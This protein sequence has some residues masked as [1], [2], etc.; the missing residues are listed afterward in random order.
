MSK[1][2]EEIQFE[3]ELKEDIEKMFKAGCSAY[4]EKA[5]DELTETAKVA[6]KQFYDDYEPKY[7]KR[8][9]NLLKNSY[10]RYYK[11]HGR[12]FEGGVY[13]GAKNMNPYKEGISPEYIVEA[14]WSGW[15]GLKGEDILGGW[16]TEGS[17]WGNGEGFISRGRVRPIY[18]TPPI[19]IVDKKMKDKK[20]L[21]DL[22][23]ATNEAMHSQ[24][25]KHLQIFLR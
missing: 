24:S 18:T 17:E 6:I 4:C 1:N 5:A 11:N 14:G 21:D 20:F 23:E 12:R 7:Y 3:K 9:E 10:K 15:H 16:G 13:I 22:E 2:K 19:S 8:T 25:Y